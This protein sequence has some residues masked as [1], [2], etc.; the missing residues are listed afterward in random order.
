MKNLSKIL[1]GLLALNA[2]I[3]NLR[4]SG[5][6]SGHITINGPRLVKAMSENLF[7]QFVSTEKNPNYQPIQANNRQF[8]STH[9]IEDASQLEPLPVVYYQQEQ[10]TTLEDLF[11]DIPDREESNIH[12]LG[13]GETLMSLS[14]MYG[15]SSQ[16]IKYTNGIRNERELRPGQLIRIPAS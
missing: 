7:I 4:Q 8:I 12:I 6:I 13:Q 14:N 5:A 10:E 1:L 16:R 2:I 11:G 15:V 9:F 3:G